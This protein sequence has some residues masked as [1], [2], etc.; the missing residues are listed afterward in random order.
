MQQVCYARYQVSF[1]LWL[2]GPVLNYKKV[3]K[4]YDQDCLKT[5][6]FLSTLPVMIQLSG[7]S[8]NFRSKMLVRSKNNLTKLKVFSSQIL[9]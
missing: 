9:T 7:K 8:T 2:F 4:Y 3:P 1:Y 6:L 5:F